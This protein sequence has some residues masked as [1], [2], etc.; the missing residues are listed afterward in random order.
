MTN[1]PVIAPQIEAQR[2]GHGRPRRIHIQSIL[3][4]LA[5]T[6]L[7]VA[8]CSSLRY[9]NVNTAPPCPAPLGQAPSLD[10]RNGGNH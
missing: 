1:S 9:T 2:T 10:C 5:V 8:A 6:L 4:A 3:A 7:A